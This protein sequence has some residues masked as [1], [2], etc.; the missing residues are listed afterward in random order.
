[1]NKPNSAIA[2]TRWGSSFLDN[3]AL[4]SAD[5][6]RAAR[7]ALDGVRKPTL[8]SRVSR[9][10]EKTNNAKFLLISFDGSAASYQSAKVQQGQTLIKESTLWTS[11]KSGMTDYTPPAAEIWPGSRN[12]LVREINVRDSARYK[13]VE[14]KDIRPSELY[15]KGMVEVA[16]EHVTIPIRKLPSDLG[17]YYMHSVRQ[18]KSAASYHLLNYR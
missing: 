14:I 6:S 8:S 2:Y 3:Q 17:N 5:G 18:F 16:T 10:K 12:K 4:S 9:R 15:D 1:M 11:L 13:K 7:Q